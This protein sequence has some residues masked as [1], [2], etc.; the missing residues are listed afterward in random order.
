MSNIDQK[1]VESKILEVGHQNLRDIIFDIWWKPLFDEKPILLSARWYEDKEGKEVRIRQEWDKV[2]VEYKYLQ[3]KIDWIKEMTEVWFEAVNLDD[4][5]LF[6][7]AIWFQ[8]NIDYRSVKT[9]VSYILDH[10]QYW[11]IRFDFDDYSEL[12]WYNDIPEFMEIEVI[13]RAFMVSVAELLW[14]TESDLKD[15]NPQELLEHY[16]KNN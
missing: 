10:E 9:R 11:K 13:K 4:A 16:H 2:K 12:G 8:E 14:F 6:L 3:W 7:E 1:E 15:Y 5:V